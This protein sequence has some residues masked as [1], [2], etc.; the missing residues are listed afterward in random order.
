[1]LKERDF[2]LIE[3]E[4]ESASV[5][6]L[7]CGAILNAAFEGSK[8]VGNCVCRKLGNEA[9]QSVFLSLSSGI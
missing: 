7:C 2:L 9:A 3:A 6:M 5:Y 4:K 8:R 1:M